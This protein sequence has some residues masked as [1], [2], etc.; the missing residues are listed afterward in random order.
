MTVEDEVVFDDQV[1]SGILS[2]ADT[3]AFKG[4]PTRE[5]YAFKGWNPT[6]AKKVKEN[7]VY[8]ATWEKIPAAKHIVT[9]DMN[10]HGIQIADQIV[11]DGGKA[12]KPDDPAANG[13]T[14]SGW[15]A[16]A[17]FSAKFDFN[18]AITDDTTIYAKWV[19]NAVGPTDSTSSKTGD[20]SHLLLFAVLMMISAAGIGVSFF[21]RKKQ[22]KC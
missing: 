1:T 17:S 11:E 12:V 18:T 3:P 13:Y 19:K 20:E 5:G 4:T 7:A 14:F 15:Y 6:V 22:S 21:M 2:G 10:G 8:T 16:D 9:F